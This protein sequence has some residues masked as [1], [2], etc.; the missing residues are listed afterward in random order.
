M[1]NIEEDEF[2]L[3]TSR[4]QCAI[5]YIYSIDEVDFDEGTSYG[6]EAHDYRTVVEMRIIRYFADYVGDIEVAYHN[7]SIYYLDYESSRHFFV[8]LE[9]VRWGV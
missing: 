8:P 2:Y 3:F 7:D 9:K 6:N 5:V 4:G 1:F